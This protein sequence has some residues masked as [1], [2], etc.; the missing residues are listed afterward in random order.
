MQFDMWTTGKT[1]VSGK[2]S[3]YGIFVFIAVLVFLIFGGLNIFYKTQEWIS[4]NKS[5]SLTGFQAL[6]NGVH[7]LKEGDSDKAYEWFAHTE[8]VFDKLQDQNKFILSEQSFEL[9]KSLYLDTANLLMDSLFNVT[10]VGKELSVF[11]KSIKS[12]PEAFAHMQ[13]DGDHATPLLSLV[14]EQEDHLN[15]IIR[16]FKDFETKILSIDASN[17]PLKLQQD[18]DQG[19][20]IMSSVKPYLNEVQQ[21]FKAVYKL[22]G[23][24]VP[25]RY[26]VLLQNNH[27]LRGTGGFIGSYL[28]IDVND[29]KITKTDSHD[30]Y[31]TDGQ[32]T[33]VVDPP[34]GIAKI[35]DR[36]FMRDA[37]Y[38]PDFPTS[39][40]EIMWF[41]E[42]SKGPSVDTVIALDQSVVEKVL[43]LTGPL[44]LPNF[45]F[46][47][48]SDNFNLLLS[49]FIE[50]KMNG[51]ASPKQILFELIPVFQE[52]LFQINHFEELY[53]I[54]ANF[55]ESRHIQLYS[56]DPNIQHLSDRLSVDGS[57]IPPNPN[58]DFL[59]IVT[60]SIGGNKSDGYIHSL[61][62]HHSDIRKSGEIINTLS[63]TKDHTWSESD[64]KPWESFIKRYGTGLT[65]ID[66]LRFIL[67]EGRN[68]DYM[69][70]YVPK[71]STLISVDGV[72]L[73]EV[74][75]SEDLG[76]TVFEFTFPQVFAGKNEKVI[77]KY[78]LP[79]SLE[80]IPK[81]S[82]RFI[83][84]KQAGAE[85]I[86]FEKTL[87]V[88]SSFDI[89][90]VYPSSTS[91]FSLD[92]H[93]KRDLGGSDFF[94][95]SLKK[96]ISI[97]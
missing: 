88:D 63:I 59:S 26:L 70:T 94:V 50:S 77:I 44:A 47:I 13:Q 78:K 29:G 34:P 24:K 76:Y 30:V 10:E 31:Q 28:I 14:H 35:V 73:E 8:Q 60:T 64:F 57:I 95:A 33:E 43:D 93:I 67:G 1:V 27:E 79:F 25:H 21:H 82:Y 71:G 41:L 32:L 23:E 22:L 85:N 84:Q 62:S 81:D 86:V 40:K 55:I 3:T 39:A 37:N 90:D 69:R 72:P 19:K 4:E 74:V 54:L 89:Q 48:R 65:S 6:K 56:I 68:I 53:K 91:V 87:H 36:L 7:Y 96:V 2:P 20:Q 12:L 92:P 46:Q 61:F 42:A 18:L 66:T 83:I 38:S 58:I 49:Y 9:E 5:L 16:L 45:P 51:E 11:L 52:Q 97:K 17:L 15:N 80:S 75:T